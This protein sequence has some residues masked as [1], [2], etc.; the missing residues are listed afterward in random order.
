MLYNQSTNNET[1]RKEAE[2]E[3]GGVAMPLTIAQIGEVFRI[4]RVGGRE[5]THRHLEELG[6]TPGTEISVVS[7]VGK[8]MILQIKDSRIAL[9]GELAKKITVEKMEG[10]ENEQ[11]E[12]SQCR[13]HRKSDK[14]RRNGSG[15]KANY[16]YGNHQGREPLYQESRS[17]W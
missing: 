3:R 13:F 14:D 16:G 6:F 10:S 2:N 15:E 9:D 12:R 5:E 4:L 11:A 8:N 7:M 1:S 17:A